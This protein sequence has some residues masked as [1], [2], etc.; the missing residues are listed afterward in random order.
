MK[1]YYFQDSP[2]F[3]IQIKW[4][5]LSRVVFAIILIVSCLIFSLRENLSFFSQPFLPLYNIVACILILSI[6]YLIWLNKFKKYLI[7]AYLQIIIDTFIVTAIVFVTGSYDS[8]FNF[9]YLVVIIYTS[10]L[11]LQKGSLIIAAISCIQ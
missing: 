5:V 2:D 10:M 4:I 3:S 6:V 8:P 11:L 1:N 9:L 7:L